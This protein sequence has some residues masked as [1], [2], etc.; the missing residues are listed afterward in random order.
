MAQLRSRKGAGG[1]ATVLMLVAFAGIGG[2]MYWLNITSNAMAVAVDEE[3]MDEEPAVASGMAFAD[4]AAD[5]ASFMGREIEV[6]GVNVVSTMGNHAFWTE[7][8]TNTPFLIRI[9]PALLEA[10]LTI[11]QGDQFNVRGQVH[12]M[13]D[14]VLDAWEAA[15]SFADEVNRIE[16]EFAE[17]FFE[18]VDASS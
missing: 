1:M 6:A 11:N 2:L 9:D 8:S 10:G 16:A 5:P 12:A 18:A 13:S 14:S 3:P 15:G 7:L 4:F 17:H